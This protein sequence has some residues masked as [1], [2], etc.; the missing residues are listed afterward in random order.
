LKY[1]WEFLEIFCKGGL[2]KPGKKILIFLERN[3]R[4]GSLQNGILHQK[5]I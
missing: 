5:E 4:N 2:E 3:L 1:T